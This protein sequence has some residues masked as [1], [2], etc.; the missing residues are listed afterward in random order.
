VEPIA[1]RVEEH[2][3]IGQ[4]ETFRAVSPTDPV[5][6]PELQETSLFY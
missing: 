4:D 2:P 1:S 5:S 3:K 6:T